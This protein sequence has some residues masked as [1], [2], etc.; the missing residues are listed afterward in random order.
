VPLIRILMTILPLILAIFESIS[1]VLD[2]RH[3]PFDVIVG[4]LGGLLCAW[5]GC[6]FVLLPNARRMEEVD[7]IPIKSNLSADTKYPESVPLTEIDAV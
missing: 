4:S 6:Q 3:H 5:V 2:N 1:R 7:E